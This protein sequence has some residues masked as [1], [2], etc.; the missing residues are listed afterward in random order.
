MSLAQNRH[1]KKKW[2]KK[3][4]P[5]SKC[6]NAKCLICHSDKVFNIPDRQTLRENSKLLTP[7]TKQL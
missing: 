1:D 6:G 7:S 4:H 3:K 2:K 5:A